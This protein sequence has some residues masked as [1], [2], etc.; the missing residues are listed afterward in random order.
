MQE[1]VIDNLNDRDKVIR[2]LADIKLN[3]YL[4]LMS[5][6]CNKSDCVDCFKYQTSR[7]CLEQMSDFDKLQIDNIFESEYRKLNIRQFPTLKFESVKPKSKLI[8]KLKDFGKYMILWIF[9]FAFIYGIISF[10]TREDPILFHLCIVV[11][12]IVWLFGVLF[13][14]FVFLES[15]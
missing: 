15:D 6:T 14:G 5:G 8:S 11:L 3:C 13:M 12:V 2:T 1:I 9:L 10:F 4:K 7:D